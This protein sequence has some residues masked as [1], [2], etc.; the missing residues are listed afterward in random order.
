MVILT[1]YIN[2]MLERIAKHKKFVNG[3]KILIIVGALW[4][5][6]FVI[7]YLI[8]LI[9]VFVLESAPF[10]SQSGIENYDKIGKVNE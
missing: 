6:Y 5:F 2:G 1:L 3:C 4:V 10:E 9:P 8:V 7:R